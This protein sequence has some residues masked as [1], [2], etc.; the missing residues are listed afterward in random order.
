MKGATLYN[1]VKSAT[2][3]VSAE[4][5]GCANL[6][7]D[8]NK[9]DDMKVLQDVKAIEKV[10]LSRPATDFARGGEG[11]FEISSF[12]QSLGAFVIR[13]VQSGLSTTHLL[14]LIAL[15]SQIC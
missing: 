12:W 6:S 13:L 8:T 7:I 5:A 2:P 14:D 4:E 3:C 11:A 15:L 10:A 1:P 9:L